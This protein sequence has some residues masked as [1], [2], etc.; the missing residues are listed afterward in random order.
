M[1]NK[2]ALI[3]IDPRF[4]YPTVTLESIEN[5][6]IRFFMEKYNNE[7]DVMP[8]AVVLFDG[9]YY[10]VDGHHRMLASIIAGKKEVKVI[11]L[12]KDDLPKWWTEKTFIETLECVGM[13]TIYDFEAIGNFDYLKIPKYYKKVE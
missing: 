9:E 3:M 11:S 10:I 8:I 6:N 4:L 5:N 2:S 1:E 12:E 7:E 13:R